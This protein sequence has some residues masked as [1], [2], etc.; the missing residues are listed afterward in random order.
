MTRAV[1]ISKP[2]EVVWP[3]LAQLGRGAGWYSFEYLDNGGKTSARHIVSWVPEPQLGD[4]SP[5]GYLRHLDPGREIV[6]WAGGCNF[7][8]VTA[9]M[10]IDI[11]VRPEGEGSRL[12]IRISGDAAGPSAQLALWVFQVIDTIMARR[13]LLG[14]KERVERY[15]CR[16]D[17]SDHPENGAREQYQFYEVIYASGER[18][19]VRGKEGAANWR[20]HAKEDK[21]LV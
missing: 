16:I 7:L 3:W 6:W 12:V 8:G 13:Q 18:A 2:P 1:S 5:I 14:I 15:G 11:A 20:Q 17:D 21:V 19:G 9:R 4:A 10:M